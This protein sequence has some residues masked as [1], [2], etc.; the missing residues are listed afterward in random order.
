MNQ[1]LS[2]WGYFVH[3]LTQKYCSFSGRARRKEF[4][5][6]ALFYLLLSWGVT[7]ASGLVFG[8]ESTASSVLLFLLGLVMFLPVLGVW[9]RRL[10]DIGKSGWWI[11]F[12]L[13]PLVGSITLLVFACL[14]SQE[15]NNAYGPSPKAL[16]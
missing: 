12:S 1:E 11:L 6:F 8:F 10:H 3:V 13:V 14:D 15:G 16:Y 4:W 9:V 2:L 5:G 7:L